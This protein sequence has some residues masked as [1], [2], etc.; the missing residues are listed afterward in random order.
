METTDFVNFRTLDVPIVNDLSG[1]HDESD[2]VID[3]MKNF[4]DTTKLILVQIKNG[5]IYDVDSDLK[6]LLKQKET[7]SEQAIKTLGGC[8]QWPNCGISDL[9][10]LKIDSKYN[11]SK[12][13]K[14][15]P[16]H[17]ILRSYKSGFD[18]KKRYH[19]LCKNHKN[20]KNEE[21]KRRRVIGLD[22]I[23]CVENGS[24]AVI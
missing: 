10:M 23:T 4:M 2:D 11:D 17:Q 18:P 22:A 5:K 7:P 19:V 1:I 16:S 13:V 14:G 6:S 24:V 20:K 12:Y 3:D 8:C 9:D 15:S 21:N